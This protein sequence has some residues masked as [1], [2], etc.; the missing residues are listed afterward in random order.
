LQL[1]SIRDADIHAQNGFEQREVVVPRKKP[2]S[3]AGGTLIV[4]PAGHSSGGEH[5]AKLAGTQARDS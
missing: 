3:F 4:V 5:S 1:G 2:L